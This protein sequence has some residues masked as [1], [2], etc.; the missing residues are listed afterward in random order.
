L[1]E[2]NPLR[3]KAGS[4]E[5]ERIVARRLTVES[6]HPAYIEYRVEVSAAWNEFQRRLDEAKRKLDAS[7]AEKEWR[8]TIEKR[9]ERDPGIQHQRGD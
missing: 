1:T 4:A 5:E 7:G 9:G 3:C 6:T 2:Y 8:K